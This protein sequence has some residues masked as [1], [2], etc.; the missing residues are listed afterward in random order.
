M[1]LT[2][3]EKEF[4]L[5][6]RKRWRTAIRSRTITLYRKAS[7]PSKGERKIIDFLVAE[8]IEFK[9]EWYFNGCFSK[10][11]NH[12]LYFD[13]YLPAYNL[14]IEY[15]GQQ[16]YSSDKPEKAKANDF[17]KNAYCL[18]NRINLLRIK[19]NDYENIEHLICEKVDK[20][21]NTVY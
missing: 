17:I 6:G 3:K 11:T 5:R 14:V 12:L 1:K 7:K 4:V 18:K 15:D 10:T 20:I 13:F 9:R 8:N 21:T 19:Y 2:K 16:H